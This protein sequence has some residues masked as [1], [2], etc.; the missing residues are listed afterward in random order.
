[1]GNFDFEK[2]VAAL[3]DGQELTGKD[4]ILTPLNGYK[5]CVSELNMLFVFLGKVY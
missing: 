1:M 2:A 4:G 3:Q 5:L